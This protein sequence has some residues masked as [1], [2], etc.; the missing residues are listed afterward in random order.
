MRKLLLLA[1]LPLILAIP[2]GAV[3]Y[4]PGSTVTPNES[5]LVFGGSVSF[6]ETYPREATGGGHTQQFPGQPNTQ[7]SCFQNGTLVWSGWTS[8]LKGTQTSI[9]GGFRQGVTYSSPLGGPTTAPDGTPL[10]WESGAAT[11]YA[12][13]YSTYMQFQQVYQIVWVTQEFDVAA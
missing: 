1:I 13:L 6:T 8:V 7:L 4:Q 2:A 5:P 3:E 10:N 12:L 9:G 11:C